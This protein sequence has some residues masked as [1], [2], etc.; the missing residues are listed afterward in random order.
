MDTLRDKVLLERLWQQGDAPWKVWER[1]P[2][3]VWGPA[4]EAVGAM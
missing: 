4:L 3:K 2:A 1:D